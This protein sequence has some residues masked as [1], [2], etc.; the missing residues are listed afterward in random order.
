VGIQDIFEI[1]QT[2]YCERAGPGA[3]DE[4][5]NAITNLAFVIA[6][7]LAGSR[8]KAYP[9]VSPWTRLLPWSLVAVAIASTVYHTLRSPITFAFDLLSLI[10]FILGAIFLVL[11]RA[12]VNTLQ[13]AVIG[14]LFLG[15]QIVLLILLPNDVLNGSISHLV[16]FLFVLLLMRLIANRY[17]SIISEGM[18]VAA[19]YAVAIVFRTIDLT[20][21]PRLPIGTHFLWHLTGAVAGFFAIRFVLMLEMAS[22]E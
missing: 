17:G 9:T 16:T 18:P 5:L 22:L 7:A 10:V 3:F 6:A 15:F 1:L 11:R 2:T 14:I 20:I 19:L 8:I 13:A 21:C 4:P 12:V